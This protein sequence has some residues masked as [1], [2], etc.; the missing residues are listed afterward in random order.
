VNQLTI[1]L[2]NVTLLL[3]IN[4]AVSEIRAAFLCANN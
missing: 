3:R 1:Y 4:K 2:I